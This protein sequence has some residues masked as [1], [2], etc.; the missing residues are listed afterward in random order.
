MSSYTIPK[1]SSSRRNAPW[2]PPAGRQYPVSEGTPCPAV[3]GD[4]L[5]FCYLTIHG[6]GLNTSDEPRTALWGGLR[7]PTDHPLGL[8]HLAGTGDVLRGINPEA[9]AASGVPSESR[10]EHRMAA[11]TA[12][13]LRRSSGRRADSENEQ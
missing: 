7:D 12:E 10:F 5:Y 6:S 4:V 9:N 3:A 2:S 1:G 11:Q 8:Q 13:A